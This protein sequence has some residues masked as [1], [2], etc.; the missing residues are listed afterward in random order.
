VSANRYIGF[1]ELSSGL[2]RD[3]G[4][5]L[6]SSEFSKK[7]YAQHQLLVP[8]LLKEYLAEDY[9]DIVELTEIM[10]SLKEKI[11]LDEVPHFTTIQKFCYRI[12]S[13]TLSRLLNRLSGIVVGA[14]TKPLHGFIN[15]IDGHS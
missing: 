7:T 9:L 8:L 15:L 3:S 13:F 2:I 11:R 14:G 5:P 1:V 10:D 4:I 6:Y 12:H